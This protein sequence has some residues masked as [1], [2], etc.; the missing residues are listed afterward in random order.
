MGYINFLKFFSFP[1]HISLK[2]FE[3]TKECSVI[4][5]CGYRFLLY[6]LRRMFFSKEK[7][8][9]FY[10]KTPIFIAVE[11]RKTVLSF[12]MAPFY[13]QNNNWTSWKQKP[14]MKSTN[15]DVALVRNKMVAAVRVQKFQLIILAMY[16]YSRF[17]T[18]ISY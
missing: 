11:S 18:F 8:F 17:I 2:S 9:N 1:A 6:N 7:I 5:G 14:P 13:L 10:I 4:W 12:N 15:K 3:L 16:F